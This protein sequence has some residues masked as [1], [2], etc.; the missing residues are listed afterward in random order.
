MT[1]STPYRAFP[2][3]FREKMVARDVLIG[4]WSALGSPIT[5]EILGMAGF[6]WILLD[7]EHGPND[8]LSLIPQL[9][10]LKDSPSAPVVRPQWNDTVIIKRLLDIG[11]YNFLI[12]F[13]QSAEDAARAVAATRYP[14]QGVRG[15]SVAHR[16]NRFGAIKDYMHAINDNIT[17]L[18]QIESPQAVN[19]IDEIASVDGVDGIFVGPSDLAAGYNHLGDITHPDVQAAILKVFEA[20]ASHGKPAG[21]LAPVKADAERYLEM[22]A[23][24]VA[25]G[26]DLGVFRSATQAL[27]N[28]FSGK[29]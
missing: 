22:G 20:A 23:T 27:R 25:V 14:P 28:A 18:V 21:I 15:V 6:D 2:N 19:A 4:C 9:M 11:F 24:F 17:V 13:V 5:T 12:P 1:D 8:V 7:G 16:S 10:S 3:Q 29:E 26:S